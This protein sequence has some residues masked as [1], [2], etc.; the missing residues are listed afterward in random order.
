MPCVFA[1]SAYQTSAEEFFDR[2]QEEGADLVLDVRL[3]NTNQLAGFTKRRDLEFFVHRI[4]GID[5]VYDKMFAPE[6]STLDDYLKKRID[7]DEY[8]RRYERVMDDRGAI[9]AFHRLYG[10]YGCVALVGTATR[11]RRSHTEV[12]ARLLADDSD[13]PVRPM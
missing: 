3:K 1:M 7:F 13:V 2:L 6:P 11:Q 4:L 10:H 12:L 5:Y 8:A 9:E